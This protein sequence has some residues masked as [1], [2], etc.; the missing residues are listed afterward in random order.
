MHLQTFSHDMQFKQYLTRWTLR[1]YVFVIVIAAV[2][3]VIIVVVVVAVAVSI[4]V[5]HYIQTF[6]KRSRNGCL[7]QL[8][9]ISAAYIKWLPV[10]FCLF[11][12]SYFS[13]NVYFSAVYR[14]TTLLVFHFISWFLFA[15]SVFP[16]FFLS[17]K[18]VLMLH[19]QGS[20]SKVVI[21]G[22]VIDQT[23]NHPCQLIHDWLRNETFAVCA[24][25]N[26]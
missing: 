13:F 16:V 26:F 25:R 2:A 17:V 15:Q 4:P 12:A 18:C 9:L 23:G 6:D 20:D 21:N 7:M 14:V 1:E 8:K 24:N 22:K 11:S 10:T 5:A 19:F 3:F